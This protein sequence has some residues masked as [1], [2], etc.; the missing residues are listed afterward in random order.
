M[1]CGPCKKRGPP[2]FFFFFS[3]SSHDRELSATGHS[4]EHTVSEPGKRIQKNNTILA[5]NCRPQPLQNHGTGK[6]SRLSDSAQYLALHDKVGE[7]KTPCR[8]HRYVSKS[9]N[10][11]GVMYHDQETLVW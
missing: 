11:R 8:E 2:F 4:C 7:G 9:G 3:F 6:Y 5:R 1:S 10:G